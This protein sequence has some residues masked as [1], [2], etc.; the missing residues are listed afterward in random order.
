MVGLLTRLKNSFR[1]DRL[2]A[3]IAEELQ[4]HLA[5][6][7]EDAERAGMPSDEARRVA[8][9]R[10]G[11]VLSLAERTVEADTIVAIASLGAD[12]RVAMRTLLR[13]PAFTIAAI[14]TLVIGTASATTAFAILQGVL[15]APLPYGQPDRLVSV[16]LIREH[17][18]RYECE[19]SGTRPDHLDL[20]V[21]DSAAPGFTNPRS[22]VHRRRRSSARTTSRRH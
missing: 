10:F 6:A 12:L 13:S 5:F 18:V 2:G 22:F 16:G 17:V 3:D 19:R 15:L 14:G 1:R 9:R 11:N 4:S 7:A 20:R 21:A 8:R